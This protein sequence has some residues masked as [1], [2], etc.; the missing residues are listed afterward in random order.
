MQGRVQGP[1]RTKNVVLSY[2]DRE[3]VD[4]CAK[5]SVVAV[6]RVAI[7]FVSIHWEIGDGDAETDAFLCSTAQM[8]FCDGVTVRTSEKSGY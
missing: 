8:R 6:T 3:L 1:P 2:S 5:L 4:L 7:M